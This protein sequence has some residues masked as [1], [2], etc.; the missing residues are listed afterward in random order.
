[1]IALSEILENW[2]ECESEA[3]DALREEII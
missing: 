1:L 3:T 2:E